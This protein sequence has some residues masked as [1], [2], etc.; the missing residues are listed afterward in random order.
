MIDRKKLAGALLAGVLTVTGATS[1]FAA[2]QTVSSPQAV[3]QKQFRKIDIAEMSAKIKAAIDNLVSK[4]T[5]TQAQADAVMK[6]FGPGD[7]R[8]VH[9]DRM[10]PLSDLVTKGTIT[11]T[12]V[13]AVFKAIKTDIMS[14]KSMEDTLKELVTAGTITEVQKEAIQKAL[15][16][17]EIMS[18]PFMGKGNSLDSLIADGTI[19]QAQVDAIQKSRGSFEGKDLS[20]RFKNS[21]LDELVTVGTIT[22][23]Q[24]DAINIAIKAAMNPLDKQ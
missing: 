20:M 7:R 24:A 11:Q 5:I 18:R 15:P 12:Q 14:D 23:A 6:F 4:G 8:Y 9:M 17:K 21:P 1:A 16:N 2:D 19:T 13:D 22:Q 3:N 10:N